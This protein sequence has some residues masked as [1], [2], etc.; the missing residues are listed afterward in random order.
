LPGGCKRVFVSSQPMPHGGFGSLG[1]AD[2]L[3]T[4]LAAAADLGGTWRA[5]LS[6]ARGSPSSRFPTGAGPYRL[7]DGTRVAADF[8][9]LTSG[10][11][12]SAIDV[13]ET[14]GKLPADQP[15]EVWTGTTP[16]GAAS[17]I[18]CGNW[19]N[20][21]AGLPYGLVGLSNR[22]DLAWTDARP[23][24]CSL[25]AAHLYCFEQ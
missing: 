5:W 15:F 19:T 13:L 14:G 20:N 6:D 23:Q 4:R 11:L 24:L 7:V 3:C 18:T 10:D 22:R 17:S 9:A 21:S 12:E 8:A 1:P 25:P 16:A 2:T